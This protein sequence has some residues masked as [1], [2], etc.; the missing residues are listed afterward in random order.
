MMKSVT[1][2]GKEYT[3]WFQVQV[4]EIKRDATL[5]VPVYAADGDLVPN[6]DYFEVREIRL[7]DCLVNSFILLDAPEKVPL[8]VFG[9]RVLVVRV[10]HTDFQRNVGSDGSRVITDRLEEYKGHSFL[11]CN[12][13]FNISPVGSTVSGI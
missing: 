8:C 4:H 3:T 6:V 1:Y 10:T 5:Q 2:S 12:P 13:L 9:R 7:C 11:L